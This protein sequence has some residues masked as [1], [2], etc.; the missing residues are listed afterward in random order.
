MQILYPHD[1]G[2]DGQ[3]VVSTSTVPTASGDLVPG[4]RGLIKWRSWRID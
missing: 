2:S 3:H 4:D 1:D